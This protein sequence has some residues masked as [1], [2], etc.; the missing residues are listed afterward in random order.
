MY[1][2]TITSFGDELMYTYNAMVDMMSILELK[3]E[4]LPFAPCCTRYIQYIY[5]YKIN[6]QVHACS[7]LC[8]CT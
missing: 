2:Q 8:T 6:P 5:V 4:P 3:K 1:V 7:V